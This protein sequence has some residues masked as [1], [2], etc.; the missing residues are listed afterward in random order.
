MEVIEAVEQMQA[1]S[2]AFREAGHIVSLVPTMGFLHAGH[3]ELMRVAKE[4]SDRLIISIF[5]NPT[6]FGPTED[7]SKYPRD[8]EGDLAK[9]QD[10]GVD[11][12]FSPTAQ[13]MYPKDFQT[14]IFIGKVTQHLCGVSRPGHFEGVCTVVAKLFN[15]TKPHIAVFGQKDYQQ[16]V[17][18][19]RMVWDLNMDLR[20]VGVPTV[21]EEDGLAMSSR[22]SYLNRQERESALCLKKSLDLAQ[23]MFKKGERDAKVILEAAESLIKNHSFTNVEY[24]SLCDPNTLEDIETLGDESLMALAVRIGNTRLIDNI[25]IRKSDLND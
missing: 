9:A 17:V 22:N 14:K 8:S 18:I 20:I 13:E 10:A 1:C 2:N 5:V 21:R 11:V 3:L 7:Y 19:Q 4:R 25:L 6:Q 24:V 15:L 12:V 23:Q 16:L